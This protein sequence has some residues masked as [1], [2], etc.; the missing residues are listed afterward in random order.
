MKQFDVQALGLEEMK[1]EE[2]KLINGGDNVEGA[3]L[4]VILLGAIILGLIFGDI[5]IGPYEEPEPMPLPDYM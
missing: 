2:Q 1:P 5:E 3:L 4:W